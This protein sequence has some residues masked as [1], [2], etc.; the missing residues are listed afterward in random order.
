[1][2]LL[3]EFYR[4]YTIMDHVTADDPE[5]GVV[6]G[7]RPGATIEMA[8]D[9]PTQAQQIIAESQRLEVVQNAVFPAGTPVS[10]GA[11]LRSVDNAEQVYRVQSEPVSAPGPAGLQI[12]KA[13]VTKARLPA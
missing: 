6:S 2:S 11:Y 13:E 5:G 9:D 1:M 8:L 3:D 10:Y 7:W 4:Q 12:M